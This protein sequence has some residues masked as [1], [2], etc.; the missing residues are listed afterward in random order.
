[1]V[2]KDYGK[3]PAQAR[4]AWVTRPVNNWPKASVL[5]AK[6]SKSDWHLVALERRALSQ[7]V[8]ANVLEQ[9][10]SASEEERK[11]NRELLKK[12]IRSLYFLVKHHIPHTTT[13][14]G[15]LTL[16]I[17]NGDVK[18]LNISLE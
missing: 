12:H 5:L 7:A 15:L 13:F 1:M 6:H 14:E 10:V 4:G 3:V 11:L 8:E 16:Q 2:C 9:M 18:L 17:E